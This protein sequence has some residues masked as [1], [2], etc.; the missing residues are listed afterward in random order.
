[1]SYKLELELS[2]I[3]DV[4][5]ALHKLQKI[6]TKILIENKSKFIKE[7]NKK[8]KDRW[9]IHIFSNGNRYIF[10]PAKVHKCNYISGVNEDFQILME[11]KVKSYTITP[12]SELWMNTN[13]E[14]CVNYNSIK[15]LTK[16]AFNK[17]K[18]EVEDKLNRDINKR[19]KEFKVFKYA[20]F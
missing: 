20:K 13:D 1:M 15:L 9:F 18:K 3:K 6:K 17:F 11:L 4:E 5:L 10:K 19:S 12:Q 14:F 8:Y 2:N 7:F 16:T